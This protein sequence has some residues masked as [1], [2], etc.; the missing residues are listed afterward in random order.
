MASPHIAGLGAYLLALNGRRAPEAL[1]D[2]I[3][4]LATSN[5]ISGLPSGTTNRLAFNGNPSG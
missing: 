3:K 4:S 2:Y 5:A 1:C